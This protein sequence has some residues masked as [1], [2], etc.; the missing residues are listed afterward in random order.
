MAEINLPTEKRPA[1]ITSPSR[2]VL[3]SRPKTGKTT[4]V[5]ELPNN[6]ILD[7][8]K[9][10]LAIAAMAIQIR[11]YSDVD[12]VC[13]AIH[14]AIKSSGKAP[15][16]YITI[17]TASSLEEMCMTQ[18]E[19]NYANSPE[20]EKWFLQNE[21]GSLHA[22][23]GKARY[24]SLT[25]LPFG[26]GQKYVADAFEAVLKKL[27]RCAPKLIIL[28]HSVT[29]TVS[30]DGVDK[31]EIDLQLSKRTRFVTMFNADAAGYLYRKGKQNWINFNASEDTTAGGR[32]RDLEKEH[33]LISEYN[34]KDELITH[35]DK[36][37]PKTK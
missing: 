1:Q 37:F 4:V 28:A 32:F 15:Y 24:G 17:D 12:G 18:A 33:I 36:I 10:S 3:F 7:F 2:L 23:S 14:A 5:A 16:Q 11:K 20:G 25:N 9:G 8:E 30:K 22:K 6:L 34:D 31:T 35:W 19:V 29:N 21:D 13:D 26:K 27:E